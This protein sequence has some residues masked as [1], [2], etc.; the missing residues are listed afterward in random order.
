[1]GR[2]WAALIVALAGAGCGAEGPQ[3]DYGVRPG[4]V[5]AMAAVLEVYGASD[6]APPPVRWVSGVSLDCVQEAN[7]KP[8]FSDPEGRPGYA[9]AVNCLGGMVS[10]GELY[11]PLHEGESWDRTYVAH[12]LMHWLKGARG[13]DGDGEHTGPEWEWNGLEA[14]VNRGNAAL[15]PGWPNDSGP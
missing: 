8:G 10:R 4:Q 2:W 1:M 11:L 5:E 14:L 6:L 7:G 9:L 12:E 15:G 13:G 3:G